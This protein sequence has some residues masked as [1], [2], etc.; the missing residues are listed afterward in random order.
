MATRRMG[1]GASK[2]QRPEFRRA[3]RT[4]RSSAGLA[5]CSGICRGPRPRLQEQVPPGFRQRLEATLSCRTIGTT[6]GTTT[7]KIGTVIGTVLGRPPRRPR[8]A[9]LR[10]HLRDRQRST[11]VPTAVGTTTLLHRSRSTSTLHRFGS[12]VRWQDECGTSRQAAAANARSFPLQCYPGAGVHRGPGPHLWVRQLIRGPHHGI[13]SAVRPRGVWSRR[14][15]RSRRLVMIGRLVLPL[16]PHP[17]H[18]R[19]A[20]ASG[21]TSDT[22]VRLTYPSRPWVA[23]PVF[24]SVSGTQPGSL[25]N[26]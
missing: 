26:R 2:F 16:S 20:P 22:R 11:L 18:V 9:P 15:V 17:A 24:S 23:S 7:T 14:L 1:T 19:S 5:W 13:V 4:K 12:T 3:P 6:I 25:G 21:G 10:T 8:R